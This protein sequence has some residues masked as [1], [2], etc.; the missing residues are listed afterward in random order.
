MNIVVP[1]LDEAK[2]ASKKPDLEGS[3]SRE[4]FAAPETLTR[5]ATMQ[6]VSGFFDA[7]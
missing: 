1:D 6:C 7:L 5:S 3:G 2:R 4:A